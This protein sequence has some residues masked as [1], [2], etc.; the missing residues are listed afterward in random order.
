[1]TDQH[2]YH[3]RSIRLPDYDYG[4]EGAY[5]VTICT[6][7]RVC[8]FG[9]VDDE[10]MTLNQY[11][12][13][14]WDEWEAT[15]K[16]RP[17]IQLDRFVVMPNH[18]HGIIFITEKI[19]P[20]SDEPQNEDKK[21]PTDT[22][23]NPINAPNHADVGAQRAAPLQPSP[24]GITP[25]NVSS[26]SLGAIVRAFKSSV[27]KRINLERNTPGGIVW[28]RNYWERI[29]RKEEDLNWLRLYIATNPAQWKKDKLFVSKSD[30]ML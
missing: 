17:N 16:L 22:S 7:E 15:A 25:N 12:R 18:V 28:Q 14:V 11:G 29:I 20:T 6:H 9:Y 23:Q 2:K 8:L 10:A 26:G 5:F 3:R 19:N 21:L 1:M 4:E 13:I 24:K 30:I 27:T